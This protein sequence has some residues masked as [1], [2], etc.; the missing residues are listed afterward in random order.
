MHFFPHELPI[1]SFSRCSTNKTA[2]NV[3]LFIGIDWTVS[4]TIW[5]C[6][7][8]SLSVIMSIK[9]S[10]GES[11]TLTLIPA[12]NESFACVRNVQFQFLLV[13]WV[14][15]VLLKVTL[16]ETSESHFEEQYV[17]SWAS[18]DTLENFATDL[19]ADLW[20]KLG[21]VKRANTVAIVRGA[22]KTLEATLDHGRGRRKSRALSS[23]AWLPLRG[24]IDRNCR[25]RV[26]SLFQVHLFMIPFCT[27]IYPRVVPL[28]P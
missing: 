2:L 22:T 5:G 10:L 13:V 11:S 24:R 19:S 16:G 1:G 7:K 9:T 25:F 28:S 26:C 6:L 3:C 23:C 20:L 21:F 8:F 27:P 18:N 14:S 15:L 4:S 12:M 17:R